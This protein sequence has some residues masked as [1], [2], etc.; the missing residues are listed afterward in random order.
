VLKVEPIW[1]LESDPSCVALYH[2]TIGLQ[3]PLQVFSNF[4]E[5]SAAYQNSESIPP[6]LLIAEPEDAKVALAS[7]FSGFATTEGTRF[8]ETLIVS[9]N[10]EIDLMRFYLRV[11]ARDYILKPLRPNE[12]VAKVE[13]A[14]MQINN[15][16]V[17]IFKND[18][19]GQQLSNLTFREH[20]ILTVLLNRPSRTIDRDKLIDSVWNKT[21]VNRKTLDVHI[22][23]LRRKLRPIGY[24]IISQKREL[25]LSKVNLEP[26][27]QE[28][29][30]QT[31]PAG[32]N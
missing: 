9:R 22:F 21:L 23:N 1:I 16:S 24:D 30:S 29:L 15:R 7:F 8:P 4:A 25:Y 20:Q 32:K 17:L 26:R 2:Q 31:I 13:R 3:Y 6:R 19:D 10:D 14:L 27:S 12:L 18:L 28:A 5:F 11:G